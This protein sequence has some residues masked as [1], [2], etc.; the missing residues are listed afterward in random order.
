MEYV[1]EVKQLRICVEN[2]KTEKGGTNTT[3]SINLGMYV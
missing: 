1:Y 2:T 3:I